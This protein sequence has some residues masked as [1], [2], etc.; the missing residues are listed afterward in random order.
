MDYFKNIW[1]Y[2]HVQRVR[3]EKIKSPA[4]NRQ[5]NPQFTLEM[6]NVVV[7]SKMY[8]LEE[9]ALFD[10]FNSD[11]LVWTDGGLNHVFTRNMVYPVNHL[12]SWF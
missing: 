6:Y 2:P 1:Y 11:F 9:A 12:M 3:L 8:L 7:F 5:G 4:Q 10:K